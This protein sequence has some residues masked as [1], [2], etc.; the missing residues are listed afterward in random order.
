MSSGATT[1]ARDALRRALH[2][3]VRD[4]RFWATQAAVVALAGLH[5][6]LD[7]SDKLE[8]SALPTGIPVILLL[9]PV[10]YAALRYGLAGGAATA[11][12]A[13]LLW[14]PDI[15][16]PD[17]RGHPAGDGIELLIVVAVGVFAGVHIDRR[18]DAERR[19]RTYAAMLVDAHEEERLRIA[20]DIHDDP[21]QRLVD[22]AR[23]AGTEQPASKDDLL[24]VIT[25]LRDIARGLRPPG[26]DEL[27]LVAAVRGLLADV[28][29]SEHVAAELD[30]QGDATR[31]PPA[32]ELTAF[33]IVQEAARNAVHH[34]APRHVAVTL[35]YTAAALHLAVRD[36]GSGFDTTTSTAFA[37]AS[38]PNGP[39]LG[40][41]GMRERAAV[42]GGSLTVASRPGRGTT[43]AATLPA[44]P[45]ADP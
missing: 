15:A 41:L 11:L 45:A 5:F 19:A 26:L 2:P 18:H 6:Y 16:L 32:V 28:E 25:R 12:L 20:R 13:T 33:R 3:P 35:R 30:V 38:S 22:V 4:P 1:R 9:I 7:A 29:D 27:G 42:L 34:A 24:D 10:L 44:R 14:L 43:V 31:L 37:E 8:P 40:L 23:R 39:H 36:D 21:L 17:A